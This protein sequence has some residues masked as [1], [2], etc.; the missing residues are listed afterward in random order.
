MA[1]KVGTYFSPSEHDSEADGI[2]PSCQTRGTI[3]AMTR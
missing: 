1:I 2:T 3:S